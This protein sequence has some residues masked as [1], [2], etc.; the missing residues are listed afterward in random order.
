[1]KLE[2]TSFILH[3]KYETCMKDETSMKDEICMKYETC[4]KDE[5]CSYK[6][7]TVGA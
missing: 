6:F 3:L 7:H 1:M 4:M 2:A 5:I